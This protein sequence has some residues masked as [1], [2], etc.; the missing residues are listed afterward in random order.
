MTDKE[1]AIKILSSLPAKNR[2]KALTHKKP[3]YNGV[4]WNFN[5]RN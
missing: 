1:Y 3:F 4:Q 5:G 2:R